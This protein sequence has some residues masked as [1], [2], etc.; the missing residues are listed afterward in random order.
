MRQ[1]DF[2]RSR[3][4]ILGVSHTVCERDHDFKPNNWFR[5][6]RDPTFLQTRRVAHRCRCKVHRRDAPFRGQLLLHLALLGC[7]ERL[8]IRLVG[9][10]LFWL[11][12]YGRGGQPDFFRR[13]AARIGRLSDFTVFT[14][15]MLLRIASIRLITLGTSRS[16]LG[17]TT[18]R[19][20]ILA[21]I[22]S[23]NFSS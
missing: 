14:C 20:S 15:F 9:P 16:A 19:P 3:K 10:R 18:C 5:G 13:A 22:N 8:P 6:H 12:F 23:R 2:Q 4:L 1:L 17:A 11:S 7:F 21:S